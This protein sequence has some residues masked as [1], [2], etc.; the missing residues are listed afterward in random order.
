M[1]PQHCRQPSSKRNSGL[2]FGM[3]VLLVLALGGCA[4]D[5]TVPP[6]ASLV[7][8]P[9]NYDQ[10]LYW[11]VNEDGDDD[12]QSCMPIS[13]L[14][15]TTGGIEGDLWERV[16]S[17]YA[18]E[19]DVD[20]RRIDGQMSIYSDKQRLFD[21]VG[22]RASWYLYYVV[23]QLEE[24]N[25][26]LEIALLPIIESG[27][28][29]QAVS[30][31]RAA[32]VWQI[33]PGTGTHLGLEQNGWY[34][35]RKDLIASTEAALDYLSDLHKRFDGDWYL[36]LAA[37]NAG[38]GS[39]QRA[40]DR[41]RRLG[42][43]TD[44]WSLPLSKQAC[45]Y[46]PR[47]IAL[48]RVLEDP[49]DHGVQIS[50]IPNQPSLVAVEVNEQVNLNQAATLAGLDSR[51]F[52]SLNA[53][54]KRGFTAPNTSNTLLVPAADREGFLAALSEIPAMAPAP[55]ERY[56][57]RPGDTLG[58]IARL[59]QTTPDNLRVLNG[60]KGDSIVAG[61]HLVLPADAVVPPHTYPT[62]AS[63][64]LKNRG[65]Y[66]VKAGDSLWRIA[67]QFGVS[68]AQLAGINGL[69]PNA[70]L[71]V[72]QQLKVRTRDD[73]RLA[74]ATTGGN[75]HKIDYQVKQGDSLSRI[76]WRFK[77]AVKQVIDWNGINAAR[78]VI[79]PG[80]SLVLYVDDTGKGAI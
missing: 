42:K 41:N 4:V 72:G 44:Y 69:S 65:V 75:R 19:G 59:H 27:Y 35:G 58:G 47:L 33:I 9:M 80:Q 60:L 32:G 23:E 50:P 13:L 34:D 5:K 76:A 20:E 70:S 12:G 25:M 17:G 24:R 51:E 45:N 63:V 40:I 38:E 29:P 31:S 53:G 1:P 15:S 11:P 8:R 36:A 56:R 26:P 46:V 52:A 28:N 73:K 54:F 6:A 71:R 49:E 22:S 74:I 66:T 21:A 43:P 39:V 67:R 16:R 7:A 57:V 37:Y 10:L 78:P 64:A 18:L 14:G 62:S 3:A 30:A 55:T 79:H 61:Q 48:S 77:V 68:T 2:V